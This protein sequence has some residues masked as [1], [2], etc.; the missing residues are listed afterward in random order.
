[1]RV[2][3]QMICVLAIALGAGLLGF[4]NKLQPQFNLADPTTLARATTSYQDRDQLMTASI[5]VGVGIAFMLFGALGLVMPWIN[6]LGSA[7]TGELGD[8][9]ARTISTI[10]IWLSI[11]MV[12]T[13]GVFRLNWTG[14]AGLSVVLIIVALIC[15]AAT[16][17]S[18]IVFGWKPWVRTTPSVS[19]SDRLKSP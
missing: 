18:A 7:M 12:L 9:S 4:S 1:M 3:M 19:E 15:S 17:T 13:F 5:T 16:I 10:T 11:A 8:N 6:K 14:T 2:F